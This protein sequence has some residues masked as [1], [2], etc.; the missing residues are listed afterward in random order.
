MKTDYLS[1][2]TYFM[3]IAL[4]SSFRSKDRKTQ[5]G[6]CIVTPDNK[7]VGIGYNGL[8]NGCDDKDPDFW[9]DDD[10]DV[11][12]SKH[13]YVVHAEQNAIY[14]STPFDLKGTA[15]YAT[16]FP[17]HICAQAIIQVGIKDVFYLRRKNGK[18]HED[19]FKAVAKMFNASG[20]SYTD[21]ADI[22]GYDS[23]YLDKMSELAP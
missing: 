14:N 18:H 10:E 17:C 1:W 16:Q 2:P 4:L 7:I 23:D 5:N 8:P 19:S 21:I 3:S 13:T 15:I 20:V 22:P 9:S 12:R 11:L 6:A